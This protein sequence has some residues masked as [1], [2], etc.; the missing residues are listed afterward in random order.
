M[1]ILRACKHCS[2]I[3]EED[4]CPLCGNPTSKEWQGYVIIIDHTKSEI[5]KRMGISVNGKFALKVR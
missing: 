1:K 3:T 4:V 2:F 5:A